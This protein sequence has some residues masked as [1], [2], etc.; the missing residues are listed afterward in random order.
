M[1]KQRL[2]VCDIDGTLLDRSKP[3]VGLHELVLRIRRERSQI[4]LVYATGRTF[5]S[6]WSL[7]AQGTLP[8]PDAIASLVG[9]ELWLPPF[10]RRCTHYGEHIA[11]RWD[12]RPV[13]ALAKQRPLLVPQDP[14]YQSPWK[15]SYRVAGQCSDTLRWLESTLRLRGIEAKF[16]YSGQRYLD[17]LPARAGKRGAVA[18]LSSYWGETQNTILACGDS[19][20]DLDLLSDPRVQGVVV[21]NAS[22]GQLNRLAASPGGF[23]SKLAFAAGVV[24]GARHYGFFR[25]ADRPGLQR[26][27]SIEAVA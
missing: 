14:K 5:S 11:T 1:G 6:T 17:I 3:T 23:R 20:N 21:G 16:L 13:R 26:M 7:V 27:H 10:E 19:G 18:Y 8:R 22:D 12:E 25:K 4:R 9:T 15:A 24:D 2:L